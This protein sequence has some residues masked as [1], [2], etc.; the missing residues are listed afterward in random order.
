MAFRK[1]D[2]VASVFHEREECC[3]KTFKTNTDKNEYN[4]SVD[5]DNH[6]LY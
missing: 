4:I 3:H 6:I 5:L 1:T 2:R